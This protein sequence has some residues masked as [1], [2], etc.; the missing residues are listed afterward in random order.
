MY[1]LHLKMSVMEKMNDKKFGEFAVDLLKLISEKQNINFT[2]LWN[3]VS[4]QP[5]TS[6][7]RKQ[8]KQRKSA[9]NMFSGDKEV[10]EKVIKDNKL[11]KE[12][13]NVA[14]KFICE[15]WKN[16]S[17]EERK[18]YKDNAD[19]YNAQEFGVEKKEK[20]K[21]NAYNM[22]VSDTNVR[23]KIMK[24]SEDK[25]DFKQ[26]SKVLSALWNNMKPEE[27]DIYKQKA[28]AHNSQETSVEESSVVVESSVVDES[29]VE[30]K[31]SV[32]KKKTP[33]SK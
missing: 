9:F 25:L 33:K 16:M 19:E 2:E 32:K 11:E 21:L 27:K 8:H 22:F 23:E 15:M 26:M 6:Y 24:E 10:R 29:Q 7:E 5:V 30:K 31:K 17:E 18:K 20:K 28:D 3:S 12:K 13:F 4:D 14:H 1:S